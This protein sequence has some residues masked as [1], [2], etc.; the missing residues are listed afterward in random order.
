[1]RKVISILLPASIFLLPTFTQNVWTTLTRTFR[2]ICVP[3]EAVKSSLFNRQICLFQLCGVTPEMNI[4]SLKQNI[5]FGFFI[6]ENNQSHC[7][8]G[9]SKSIHFH[10][11]NKNSSLPGL[12]VEKTGS[13]FGTNKSMNHLIDSN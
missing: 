4:I 9:I 11:L 8:A 3:S 2:K 12:S 1:M 6:N 13:S 10:S 7:K 5:E